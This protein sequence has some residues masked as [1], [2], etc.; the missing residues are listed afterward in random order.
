MR[1]FSSYG[2]ID[3]DLH[4]YAPRQALVEH[5]YRQLLGENPIKD[6]HYITV[7]APRQTGKT[8]VMQQILFSLQHEPRYADFAVVKVNLQIFDQQQD[9]LAIARYIADDITS[10]LG[11]PTMPIAQIA[12]FQELFHQNVLAKP[13]VLMLD[14]FD[15]LG[16]EAIRALAAIFRNIYISR[17]DQMDIPSAQKAYLLHGVALIGVRAVLGIENT[18]GS[19]F[20]VQ[21][22][23]HI[24][25]LT[26]AE[27]EGMFKW[28]EQESG[29][30]VEKAVIEEIFHETQ[31][32]PGLIGWLGELL[33]ETYNETPDLPLT[34]TN[35]A[36]TYLWATRG[37][38]NNNILNIVSKA[39]QP[40]YQD[41]VLSLFKTDKPVPFNF[42]DPLLNFLYL[43]GVITI[44][45]TAE[46]LLTKFA[47]PFV[48]KRLFH[49]FAREIF[50]NVGALY[51]PFA[52]LSDTI[53][54]E[55]LHIPNL[56][57]RYEQYLL[58]F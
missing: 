37:L 39:K 40:P 56:M 1:K 45:E 16:E 48:Q 32:Q 18:S 3:T 23:L 47:S 29:Q 13:L 49:Y 30:V 12:D 34:M 24:P 22:S 58:S 44:A 36:R 53:T 50:P 54:N 51:D 19:P 25:N 10:T 31:G 26:Y 8:W 4:Y 42:D 9:V 5:A 55:L 15:A 43:N 27:V 57:R 52:D 33:T 6:G 38:P 21:R 20:N 17:R 7:W 2:P 46:T 28:Y 14:E 41:V 35:F 11:L